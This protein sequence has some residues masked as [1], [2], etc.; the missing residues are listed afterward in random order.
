VGAHSAARNHPAESERS[1]SLTNWEY[2]FTVFTPTYN[3]AHSL[4]R[5][6]SSLREQTFDDFE[7]LIV[8]DGST[9]GTEALVGGW[10]KEDEFPI[11]YVR[12]A[13]G[14]KHSAFNAAVRAARGEFFLNLDSD[15]A[16]TADALERFDWHWRQIADPEAFTGVTCLCVDQHGHVVGDRFPADVFDSDSLEV[17]YRYR[18]G[19]EKWG[20]HRTEVI[21]NFPFPEAPARTYVGEGLIWARIARRYKT[22]FVNEA[23]RIYFIEAGP[24]ITTRSFRQLSPSAPFYLAYLRENSDWLSRRPLDLLRQAISFLRLVLHGRD[25]RRETATALQQ[26]RGLVRAALICGCL[27]ALL[28][29]VHD[30]ARGR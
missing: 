15:D 8:D 29:Y 14:G 21:R 23:L 10:M 13:N 6:Y 30:R 7:W 27:P 3:R 25:A 24:R 5:V 22:R 18:V 28:L 16:C 9:D 1:G 17:F 20:F 11:R 2:R 19:G 26:E 4:G 12:Q